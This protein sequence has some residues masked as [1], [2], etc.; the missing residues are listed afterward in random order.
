MTVLLLLSLLYYIQYDSSKMTMAITHYCMTGCCMHLPTQLP[1][2]LRAA[3]SHARVVV[4]YFLPLSSVEAALS[5]VKTLLGKLQT[6]LAGSVK[7]L[8]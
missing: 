2:L 3:A 8:Q 6:G 5:T 4:K 7:R 1:L